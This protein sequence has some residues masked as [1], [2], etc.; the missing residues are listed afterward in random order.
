MSPVSRVSKSFA[1]GIAALGGF[2]L[3][4]TT[5]TDAAARARGSVHA[6]DHV[7]RFD[8]APAAPPQAKFFT[9]NGVLAKLD[10]AKSGGNPN[11]AASSDVELASLAPTGIATDTPSIQIAPVNGPEPFGLFAFRA[12][13]GALWRKWRGL[14][15]DMAKD[16]ESL[17]RCQNDA[18]ACSPAAAKF[19]RLVASAKA[20]NGRARL[21]DVNQGIN[22]AI[23]Y[24]SDSMQYGVADRW[25]SALSSFA[26]GQGDCEDYAIAKYAALSEAGFAAED[27]RLVL[28][29]DR[30]VREDHAVLAVH[31]DGKWLIMDNRSALLREDSQISSFTPLF[32]INHRGVQLF[33]TPY[34]KRDALDG[35]IDALPAADAINAA[36]WN[37]TDAG[38]SPAGGVIGELP[39]LM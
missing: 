14:E 22:L 26:T 6:A 20:K 2:L 31:H 7:L 35:Q 38:V 19:A 37:G 4:A 11:N 1:T 25:S 21:E 9:I 30:A 33:A 5:A 27:L 12:P 17:H 36:E 34:A 23:R 3:L 39:L 24:V 8:D 13:E 10:A 32:A 15:A 16:T 29:R 28:V 18:S